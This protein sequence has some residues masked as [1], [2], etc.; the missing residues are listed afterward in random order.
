MTPEQ[1]ETEL[2]HLARKEDVAH[3]RTEIE[4]LRAEL[5]KEIAGLIK[6]MIA[7]QIPTWLGLIGILLKH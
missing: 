5:H 1:I 7:L 2:A 4:T 6:W 3:L